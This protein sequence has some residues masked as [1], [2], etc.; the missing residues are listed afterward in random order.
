VAQAAFTA[1]WRAPVPQQ[2]FTPAIQTAALPPQS[3]LKQVR[4]QLDLVDFDLKH[5]DDA[6]LQD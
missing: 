5:L 3:A 6:E 2:G 1:G 4:P